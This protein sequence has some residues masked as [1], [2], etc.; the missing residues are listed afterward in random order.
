[1][2]LGLGTVQFG[3]DYGVSN[4]N[5]KAGYD[6][7]NKILK[8]AA[9]NE[10]ST[11]D[12]AAMYGDAEKVIGNSMPENSVFNIISKTRVFS[13]SELQGDVSKLIMSDFYASLERLGVP[14]LY[15]LLVH[16]VDNLLSSNGK[17]ILEALERLKAEGLVKKIGVSV[18]SPQ[19]VMAILE[20]YTPDIVQLPINIFDQRMHNSGA[21]AALKERGVEV[22]ARS[23]FL[24]GLLLMDKNEIDSYFG[25][26]MDSISS[27]HDFIENKTLNKL[28]AC[29]AFARGLDGYIDAVIVG[30]TSVN[31]LEQIIRA[32]QNTADISEDFSKFAI[33]DE[34]LVNPSNWNLTEK[35]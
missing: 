14:K 10:M 25:K 6:T 16:S 4:R 15:G 33:G 20:K 28:D 5:G 7:A 3:L 13:E 35:R 34:S 23:V 22:H 12:T 19:Q 26:F 32:W 8:L 17:K 31:E 1:M 11:L 29:L 21:L 2:R 30:A 24:Q 18:Y 9:E 27:L